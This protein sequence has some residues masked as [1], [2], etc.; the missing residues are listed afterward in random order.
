MHPCSSQREL[1][2]GSIDHSSK[3]EK[4]ALLEWGTAT[5]C[6]ECVTP[7]NHPSKAQ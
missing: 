6:T 2:G 7:L 5:H 1:V 4:E 3:A